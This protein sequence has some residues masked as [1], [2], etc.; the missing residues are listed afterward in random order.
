M[1]GMTKS[2]LPKTRILSAVLSFLMRLVYW[3]SPMR[4][5]NRAA[6]DKAAE[7]GPIIF[8]VWHG[9]FFPFVYFAHKYYRNVTILTSLSQDGELLS[10]VIRSFG[11]DVVRGDDRKGGVQGLVGMIREFR[12]GRHLVFAADGPL[13]PRW[14]LKPGVLSCA[15]K[16][17]GA[18]VP[19]AGSASRALRFN[20]SWDRFLFAW[21]FSRLHLVF[22]EPIHYAPGMSAADQERQATEL[23]QRLVALTR[24]SDRLAG[25][26]PEEPPS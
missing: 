18:V 8:V 3:T 20:K 11:G 1:P 13:G 14:K 23:E 5:H 17:G 12:K 26:P 10:G 25:R 22:G 6:L 15:A 9:R 4:I 2:S 19:M 24:E 7:S 21:P 16:T